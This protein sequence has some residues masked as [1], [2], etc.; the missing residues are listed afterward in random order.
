MIIRQHNAL[1]RLYRCVVWVGI[2][3]GI[4]VLGGPGLSQAL[5]VAMLIDR[6]QETYDRTHALTADF[7]QIASLT[8]INRQQTSAGRLSIEKPH[9]LRWEYTQPDSQTV[10]YDGTLLRIYTPKR[11]QVLQSTIDENNRHNVALLFLAGMGK[12]REA[13]TV[14]P[15]PT[16]DVTM[17]RLR[18]L[19][20]SPQAS[21]TELHIAVNTQTYLIEHLSIH[22]TIG[23][24][25]DIQL[26][27]L[28]EHPSL[29]PGTFELTLPPQTEILTP[30]DVTGQR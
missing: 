1:Q 10:L 27:S 14:S 24:V 4:A 23:N 28:Q 7:V 30:A 29:P 8:S 22:D 20:R 21:F 5:E 2:W 3:M 18:L 6:M 12:L 26:S 13:F 19:P 15:L 25:T 16:T 9:Y 11:Q 17:Q